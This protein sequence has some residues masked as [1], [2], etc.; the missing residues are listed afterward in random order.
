MKQMEY[1]RLVQA[2]VNIRN[3]KGMEIKGQGKD[4]KQDAKDVAEFRQMLRDGMTDSPSMREMVEKIG[5][6]QEDLGDDAPPTMKIKVGHD[7]E[8]VQGDNF[9]SGDVDLA[10]LEKYDATVDKDHPEAFT[11][12]EIIMHILGER[13]YAGMNPN[14][15]N[16]FDNAHELGGIPAQNRYR[17]ERGQSK[18]V[19]M[20]QPRHDSTKTGT[21]GTTEFEGGKKENV[22]FDV[23]GNITKIEKP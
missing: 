10:D 22:T 14:E 3:E 7:Q 16:L 9:A 23:H 17:T 21:V 5:M 6:S 11:R 4:K 8:G 13:R 1:E 20:Y 2:W 19:D 12:S 18:V 15:K